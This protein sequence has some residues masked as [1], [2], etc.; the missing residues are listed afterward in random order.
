MSRVEL[1]RAVALGAVAFNVARA[2]G[3][4]LAGA[5]AAWLGTGSALI[6]SALFFILMIV[7]VRAVEVARPRASRR[8]GDAV[9]RRA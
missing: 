3:P 1:P 4:A 6:A 8:A 7:A 2:I 5:I 9:L